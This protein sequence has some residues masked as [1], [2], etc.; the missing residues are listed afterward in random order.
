MLAS[1]KD[2]RGGLGCEFWCSRTLPYA[3]KEVSNGSMVEFKFTE[4]HFTAVHEDL[5]RLLVAV[6]APYCHLDVLVAHALHTGYTEEERNAWWDESIRITNARADSTIPIVTCI[7][8]NRKVGSCRSAAIGSKSP[9]E[10]NRNGMRLHELVQTRRQMLPAT[11]EEFHTG[12]SETWC[13]SLGETGQD[14]LHSH[15]GR[16]GVGTAGSGYGPRHRPD[17][18]QGKSLS[19]DS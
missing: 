3:H 14:R 18:G 7:D 19:S 8:A 12:P 6:R 1:G 13:S 15:S 9:D 16:L 11:F 10:E 5:H 17:A 2:A 4:N